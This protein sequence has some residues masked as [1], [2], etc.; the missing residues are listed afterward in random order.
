LKKCVKVNMLLIAFFVVSALTA[1]ATMPWRT[2]S[3]IPELVTSGIYRG[4]RPDF[5][6]LNSIP[7]R[8]ILSLEDNKLI[9]NEE[10][11]EASKYGIHFINIPLSESSPP[12]VSAL[13]YIAVVLAEEKKNNIYIHCRRGID[14]SG[15]G[16]AAYRIIA[17]G[18]NFNKAY[19][20]ILNHGHSS[21]Y[22]YSWKQ[23]LKMLV[24]EK[25]NERSN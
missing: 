13:T 3:T 10:R 24:K 17:E 6:K 12:E 8:V 2:A 7:I 18:W 4:P 14:R 1:C 21:L 22:F 20:E 11:L 9:V 15:Y 25:Q 19:E 16:V 23:S 5:D